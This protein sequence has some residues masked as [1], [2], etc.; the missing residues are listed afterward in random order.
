MAAILLLM[1][2]YLAV[3]ILFKI[4]TR[5]KVQLSND[6]GDCSYSFQGSS[7]TNLCYRYTCSSSGVQIQEKK[8]GSF[9][10]FFSVITV[11]FLILMDVSD[12]F[13]RSGAG[14]GGV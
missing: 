2:C 9:H 3:S 10:L 11:T 12:I 5:M 14:E 13:F 7:R 8:P 4:I 6:F 1:G